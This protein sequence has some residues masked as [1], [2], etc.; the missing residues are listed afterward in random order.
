[1]LPG[2]SLSAGPRACPPGDE[3]RTNNLEGHSRRN[4]GND[5]TTER[6]GQVVQASIHMCL[7]K[8]R[9]PKP[10]RGSSAPVKQEK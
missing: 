8:R 1:M 3:Q 6:G 10:L 7:Y 2:S 5:E 9:S 4:T